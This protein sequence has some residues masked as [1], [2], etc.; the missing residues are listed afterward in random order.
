MT[1]LERIKENAE[2]QFNMHGKF[3]TVA[4]QAQTILKLCKALEIALREVKDF[5]EVHES[6]M[7]IQCDGSMIREDNTYDTLLKELSE[8]LEGE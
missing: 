8:I 6:Y 7:I 1:E 4:F 3:G 5:A 2:E